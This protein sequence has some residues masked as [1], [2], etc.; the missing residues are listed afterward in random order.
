MDS[1]FAW[2]VPC[3]CVYWQIPNDCNWALHLLSGTCSLHLWEKK[4]LSKISSLDTCLVVLGGAWSHYLWLLY[5]IFLVQ[6][7]DFSSWHWQSVFLQWSHHNSLLVLLQGIV[8]FFLQPKHRLGSS[9]LLSIWYLSEWGRWNPVFQ[10]LEVT[11]LMRMTRLRGPQSGPSSITGGS[12]S[13]EAAQLHSHCLF[14]WKIMWALGWVM[15]FP[16]LVLQLPFSSSFLELLGTDSSVC[17]K[18][19]LLHK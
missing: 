13:L 18:E 17:S 1:A 9:I 4:N 5:G 15:E 19:A 6:F 11:S 10:H 14:M 7:R 2:W 8:N 16:L 12:R 3:G